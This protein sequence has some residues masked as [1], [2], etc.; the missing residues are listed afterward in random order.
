MFWSRRRPCLGTANNI[1]K[2]RRRDAQGCERGGVPRQRLQVLTA[3]S[4]EDVSKVW[5]LGFRV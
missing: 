1:R 4:I 3:G 2:R 5:G